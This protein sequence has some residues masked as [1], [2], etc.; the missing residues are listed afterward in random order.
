MFAML[1]QGMYVLSHSKQVDAATERAHECLETIR[2]L[3][4]G[5]IVVG[6]YDSRGG[7]IPVSGFPPL[8]YN[9]VPDDYPMRVDATFTGA[10][11]NTISVKV[12]VY[13]EQNRKVSLQTYFNTFELLVVCPR[14]PCAFHFAFFG[15]SCKI[16]AK[17]SFYFFS[18]GSEMTFGRLTQFLNFQDFTVNIF[19]NIK[20]NNL[21]SK[22]GDPTKIL[23]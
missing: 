16:G 10:P 7:D 5:S 23:Y 3:G 22:N 9:S 17:H 21:I 2:A 6:T 4:V 8:P 14:C 11:P 12:D 13:Y 19:G 18:G 15:A 20:Y 1:T